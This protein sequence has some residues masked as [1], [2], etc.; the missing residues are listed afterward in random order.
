MPAILRRLSLGIL[1]IVGASALLLLSDLGTRNKAKRSFAPPLTTAAPG[2]AAVPVPSRHVRVAILQHASQPVLDDG[3]AGAIAGLADRGWIEGQ[4]LELKLY[5]AQGD[6]PTAQAIAK[7]MTTGGYDLL[8]TISTVSLQAVANANKTT[9]VPHV[10]GLVTD[11][12]GAGV[13]IS[14][15]NHLDH[16]AWLAGYATMQPV[17]LAFKTAREMNPSLASVGVIWNAAESNSEAQ[18]KIARGVCADLGIKLLEATVDNSAGVAEAA[19]SLVARG[20]DAI[21]LG[22]DVMVLTAVDSVI[23]AARK[24]GIPVFTVIPPNI[25]RGALFDIGA[26]YHEVGRLVGDLAGDILNGRDPATVSVDNVMPEQLAVNQR[27]LAGLRGNWSIPPGILARAQMVIDENGV[28]HTK[29]PPK[30]AATATTAAPAIKPPEPGRTYHLAFVAFAPEP[31][32]EVCQKGLLDG[33]AKLGFVEGKNLTVART[34]AQGEMVNIPSMI[35]NADHSDADAIVSFSTPVLQ[36]AMNGAKLKP[37][38]FTYVT[39]PLAAGAGKSFTDHRPNVTGVGSLPPIEDTIQIIRRALP[40]VQKLGTLYNAGEANS[41]KIISLLRESAKK[42]GL[43]LVELTVASSN[44]IVQAAQGLVTRGVDAIYV[45]SDNTA[46][47]AYDGILKVAA[48]AHIPVINDDADYLSRGGLLSCG[49]GFYYSGAAAA[50]ALTRVLGGESPATIPLANVSVNTTK[51]NRATIAKLGLNIPDAL[52]REIEAGGTTSAAT[53][54]QAAA[55][56]NPNP[57]GRKW[58]IAEIAYNETP[59]VEQTIDGMRDAWKHSRLVAG[60]DYEITFRSAQGDMAAISGIVDAARTEGADIIVPIC[61]PALQVAAQKVKDRPVIFTLVANPMAAGAGKSYTDH[62]PN[63]TG[64]AVLAPFDEALDLITKNF[65]EYRRFGTLYCPA[66]A[67]SVDLKEQLE[68]SC[69][70]RGFTLETVAANSPTDLPDAAFA[71]MSRPIDAVL[72]LSDNLTSSGFSAITRA[73]RQAKKPLL[74]LNS[75]TVPLGAAFAF[76]RNYF[77]SGEAT[78]AMIERV[79]RGENP[80]QMPFELPPKIVIQ[81][82]EENARAV[83]MTLPPA[84]LRAAAESAK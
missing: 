65:P 19:N 66:E 37:I 60:R 69:K 1:L 45:P 42:H 77:N 32:L 67:N 58:K 39:D 16:P 11:P 81:A 57:S 5:N 22:G 10:F 34:H 49:P 29:A 50:P 17:A 76:G 53:P 84:L 41:V 54:A 59:P 26:N 47:L 61:T 2:A 31:S 35:Q 23:G 36:G 46:Y 48:G 28:E 52:I 30:P 74:S 79:I 6:M 27:A 25:R 12:Y 83:G 3:R 13:G 21:W 15:T 82:S 63:V 8:L 62:L 9:R 71:L 7:E 44:E 14:R 80:A 70:R 75:T 20:V 43:D 18:V 51:F 56:A 64:I 4:N 38:V 24:A 33:L 40:Q 55:A 73:A 78:V 68:A 72:Q